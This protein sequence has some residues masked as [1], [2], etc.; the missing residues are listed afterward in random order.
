MA[1]A[2]ADVVCRCLAIHTFYIT[3]RQRGIPAGGRTA[4]TYRGGSKR[5]AAG[6]E[7]NFTPFQVSISIS[8]LCFALPILYGCTRIRHPHTPMHAHTKQQVTIM[9]QSWDA[10]PEHRPPFRAIV[11]AWEGIERAL[12]DAHGNAHLLPTT[13]VDVLLLRPGQGRTVGGGD[14]ERLQGNRRSPPLPLPLSS[15]AAGMSSGNGGYYLMTPMEFRQQQLNGQLQRRPGLAALVKQ[16][17]V[18]EE[19]RACDDGDVSP[20]P[21]TFDGYDVAGRYLHQRVQREGEG[22][23]GKQRA[24]GHEALV[25]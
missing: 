17:L 1:C 5:A 25:A 15:S 11:R 12:L 22:R 9:T 14:R 7:C 10:A 13:T 23:G 20:V 2:V 3:T 24:V 8:S 16:G 6:G 4:A 21:Q 18:G 19:Q